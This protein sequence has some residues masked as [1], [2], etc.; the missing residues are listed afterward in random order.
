[1]LPFVLGICMRSAPGFSEKSSGTCL[2][3]PRF[4][5]KLLYYATSNAALSSVV[6]Y[7]DSIQLV[8]PKHCADDGWPCYDLSVA[9]NIHCPRLDIVFPVFE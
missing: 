5:Y 6:I 7:N 2:F 4:V 8:K 1:M 3:C 9:V